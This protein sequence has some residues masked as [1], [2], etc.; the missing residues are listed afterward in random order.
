MGGTQFVADHVA[1]GIHENV[2]VKQHRPSEFAHEGTSENVERVGDDCDLADFTQPIDERAS[3]IKRFDLVDDLDDLVE[4]QTVLSHEIDAK[5]HELVEVRFVARGAP[6][7]GNARPF[8]EGNPY[9]G[10]EHPFHVKT[11]DCHLRSPFR[12]VF[13]SFSFPTT[14]PS[15]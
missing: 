9:F 7:F 6:E 5:V 11:D 2:V 10:D 1:V 15:N 3:T 12:F 14:I 8:G 13:R 4:R